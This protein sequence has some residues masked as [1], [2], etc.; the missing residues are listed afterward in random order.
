VK[1]PGLLV[2]TNS[3]QEFKDLNY[4]DVMKTFGSTLLKNLLTE[5]GLELVA[6]DPSVLSSFL[7]LTFPVSWD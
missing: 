4:N 2:T 6:E 3:L 5:D 7:I 1:A